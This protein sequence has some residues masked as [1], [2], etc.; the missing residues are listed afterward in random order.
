[1]NT[2]VTYFFLRFFMWFWLTILPLLVGAVLFQR[3]MR[4]D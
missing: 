4:K 1:M 2:Y 3:L